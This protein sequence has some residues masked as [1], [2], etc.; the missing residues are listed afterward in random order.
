M[1]PKRAPRVRSQRSARL[2]QP[3]VRKDALELV[4]GDGTRT[5]LVAGLRSHVANHDV[6]HGLTAQCRR[7]AGLRAGGGA[8]PT[9]KPDGLSPKPSC[10]RGVV[11]GVRAWASGALEALQR[12]SQSQGR[13]RS[14]GSSVGLVQKTCWH[15]SQEFFMRLYS[16]VTS[17]KWTIARLSFEGGA[18]GSGLGRVRTSLLETK[19]AT[20]QNTRNFREKRI[21]LVQKSDPA[22]MHTGTKIQTHAT[23]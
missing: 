8:K 22:F 20:N 3:A 21:F 19:A 14:S 1:Y 18:G 4:W 15:P 23:F 6:L 10:Q 12:L 13:F 5:G 7:A 2:N 11:E 16:K 17:T 9:E